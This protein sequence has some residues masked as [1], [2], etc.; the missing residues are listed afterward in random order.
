MTGANSMTRRQR[1]GTTNSLRDRLVWDHER[2][3]IVDGAR[4]YLMLRADVLMGLFERLHGPAR[5]AALVALADAVEAHGGESARAYFESVGHDKA[6]LLDLMADAACDL[7]WG[8]WCF[9]QPDASGF[10]LTVHDS[11]F[12]A[13]MTS[14]GAPACYAI[15]GMM[16]AV[17]RLIYDQPVDAVESTCA[18]SGAGACIVHVVPVDARPSG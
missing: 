1:D 17:G 11:P 2:G 3:A 7:G 10:T 16:R 13:A 18:A 5:Q 4:R 6:K 14:S 12:A 9:S 8:R 15:V